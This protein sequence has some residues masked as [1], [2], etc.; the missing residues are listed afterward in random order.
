M[1]KRL[2]WNHVKCRPGN[3]RATCAQA[4]IDAHKFV[5]YAHVHSNIY[6]TSIGGI[7]ALGLKGKSA[8]MD[9]DVQVR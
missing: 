8:V 5:E 2:W 3:D 4:N 1:S 7:Q 9:I 6:G